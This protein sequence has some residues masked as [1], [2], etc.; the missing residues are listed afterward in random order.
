MNLSNSNV[1]FRGKKYSF[2]YGEAHGEL[3]LNG[4]DIKDIYEI[5]GLN[6]LEYLRKLDLSDNHISEIKGLENL[7][8][9]E[10]LNLSR[11]DIREIRG[12]ENLRNLKEIRL[13]HNKLVEIDSKDLMN[14][15]YLEYL[16]L[17]HNNIRKITHALFLYKPTLGAILDGNP[18]FGTYTNLGDRMYDYYKA[19]LMELKFMGIEDI[20]E[21]YKINEYITLELEIDEIWICVND[22]RFSDPINDV[23][24]ISNAP[25]KS[26]FE[27]ICSVIKEWASNNYNIN[28]LPEGIAVPL[29]K[30]LIHAGDPIAKQALKDKKE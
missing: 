12:L 1:I 16:F 26:E 3:I 8:N 30:R 10:V 27:T 22:K 19:E 7:K 17:D 25:N 18:V 4:L 28:L 2:P 14:L 13:S 5:E 9:L 20:I 15:E 21:V 29:L 23:M 6:K 11:N 24:T